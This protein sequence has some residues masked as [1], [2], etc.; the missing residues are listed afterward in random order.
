[1]LWQVDPSR[2]WYAYIPPRGG[3]SMQGCIPFEPPLAE[4]LMEARPCPMA[5]GIGKVGVSTVFIDY[6]RGCT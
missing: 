6:R 1:M 4:S 5:L 2:I 3:A